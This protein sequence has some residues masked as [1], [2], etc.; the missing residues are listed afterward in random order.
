MTEF[1]KPTDADAFLDMEKLPMPGTLYDDLKAY[2][3]ECPQCR[4]YGGWNLELNAYPVRDKHGIEIGRKHFQSHCSHCNGWGWVEPKDAGHVH[5]W[6]H[7]R[8]MGNCLNLFVCLI[9]KKTIE[10]DSSG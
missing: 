7:V 4:G 5:D 6:Q 10:V 9:C 1:L 3:A 8:R 2:T